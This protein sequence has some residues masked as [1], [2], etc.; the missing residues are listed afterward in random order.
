MP[1][2]QLFKITPDSYIINL[3]LEAFGLTGLDDTRY[4]TR[5]NMKD[6]DTLS[7]LIQLSDE[8]RPYY[9]PCKSKIYIDNLTEKKCITLFRQFLKPFHYKCMG[10]EKSIQGI[11]QMT[12]RV[13]PQDKEQVSPTATPRAREY[14]IDFSV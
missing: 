8:L 13:M 9:L 2:S 4:F 1:K 5:E 11:K 3:I 10:I 6:C 14:V 12:Y 7:I